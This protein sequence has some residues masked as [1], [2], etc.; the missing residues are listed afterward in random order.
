[1]PAWV[2]ATSKKSV[3]VP[4]GWTLVTA[5]PSGRHS[6]RNPSASPSCAAL[7]AEYGAKY[8]SPRRP[9]AGTLDAKQT[10]HAPLKLKRT[11]ILHNGDASNDV[12]TRPGGC[13]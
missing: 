1:M 4:I 10:D 12:R 2:W 13:I 8:G 7:V 3:S 9:A 11:G 6:T 5:M